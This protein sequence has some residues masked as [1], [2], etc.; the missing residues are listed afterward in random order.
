MIKLL[1]ALTDTNIGGA[2][3][4]L[5]NFL[6]AYDRKKYDVR[7]VLPKNSDLIEKVEELDVRVYALSSIADKSF[8]IEGI[9]EFKRLFKE[10]K[11]DIIHSHASL[12]A[13]IAAKMLGIK[14]VNTRHCLEDAKT[15]LKKT[16]YSF[17]NNSLSSAVVGVSES[18]VENLIN[19]GTKREK[20]HL[21]YNGATPPR[22][23][24]DEQKRKIKE[25]L[26]IPENNFVVGIIARLE[27][28][29]N[30][31]L[32]LNSAKILLEK[33]KNITFIIVGAGSCMDSLKEFSKKLKIEENVIFT[34]YSNDI[35]DYINIF[36]VNVLT[37]KKEALSLSLIEGMFVGVPAVATNSGGPAEV[38][39]DEVT[40]YILKT[41][42]KEELAQKIENLLAD[43]IL[44]KTMGENGKKRANE[45]FSLEKMIESLDSLYNKL[46]VK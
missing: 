18:A 38:V 26:K 23:L 13:R 6:K 36:D 46:I 45:L 30:H 17:I 40:G 10:L 20:V 16:V 9:S 27:P 44:R 8:S 1:H 4:W 29:K 34:G 43:E 3:I 35:S 12:S 41:N 11:P 14:T 2:G 22:E 7:V 21:I 39:L 19:D 15:G 25:S 5:L 33:Q 32:F 42:E 31:E 37:S 24:C 28:V